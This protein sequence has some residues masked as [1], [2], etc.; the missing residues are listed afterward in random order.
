MIRRGP[1]P[2]ITFRFKNAVAV[3]K[4]YFTINQGDVTSTQTDKVMTITNGTVDLSGASVTVDDGGLV[5]ELK[6]L[7]TQEDTLKLVEDV[8][9]EAQIRMYKNGIAVAI[10]EFEYQ[11]GRILRDGVI[12]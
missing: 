2:T 5:T 6:V 12:S 7:L 1:T 10:G 11:T 4:A 9:T 3:D 8:P